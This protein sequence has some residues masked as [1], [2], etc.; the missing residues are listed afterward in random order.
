MTIQ[1]RKRPP[2]YNHGA[3]TCS[4]GIEPY[5]VKTGRKAGKAIVRL[6]INYGIHTSGA[7]ATAVA[8]KIIER[9]NDCYIYDG[10][11]LLHFDGS[12][13][14]TP[15]SVENYFLYR[16]TTPPSPIVSGGHDDSVS[17]NYAQKG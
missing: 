6:V 13:R 5:N 15:E 1:Y 11:M 10:P 17:R 9:L 16:R 14:H 4:F 8:D 2:V 12:R 3:E 7:E